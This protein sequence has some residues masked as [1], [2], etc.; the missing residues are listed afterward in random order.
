[1]RVFLYCT[2]ISID[3]SA[4]SPQDLSQLLRL[5]PNLKSLRIRFNSNKATQNFLLYLNNSIETIDLIGIT[6]NVVLQLCAK[7]K[8]NEFPNLQNV[9]IERQSDSNDFSYDFSLFQDIIRA[10]QQYTKAHIIYCG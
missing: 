9:H 4:S 5:T 3:D 1:V 10:T 6:D 8:N 7:I 2:K